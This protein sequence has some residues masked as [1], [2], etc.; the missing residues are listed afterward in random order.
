MCA[1]CSSTVPEEF[2]LEEN[3]DERELFEKRWSIPVASQSVPLYLYPLETRMI[4][5]A[6]TPVSASASS[7]FLYIRQVFQ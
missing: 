1:E 3:A 7:G 6:Y 4:R 5:V 2:K